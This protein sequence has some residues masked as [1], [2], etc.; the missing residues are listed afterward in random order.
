M[1]RLTT[2]FLR[3]TEEMCIK[4][5]PRRKGIERKKTWE[6]ENCYWRE[7]KKW[8]IERWKYKD[9]IFKDSAGTTDGERN[10]K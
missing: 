5:A 4:S 10:D 8:G 2:C 6:T 3:A 1:V 9:K 7:N